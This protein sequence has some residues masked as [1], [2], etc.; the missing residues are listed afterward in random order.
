MEAAKAD[1][2]PIRS[3]EDLEVYQRAMKLVPR[4]YEV[5][6]SMPGFEHYDLAA[7]VRRAAKSVPTNIAEGYARRSSV[8]EFKKFLRIAMASANEMEV[9]LN[10]A[11]ELGYV[12][13]KDAEVWIADYDI[14]GRQLN[15]LIATWRS[16]QPPASSLKPQET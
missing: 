4:M 13:K 14:V 8:K 5:A 7:Q 11:A 10:I 2:K 12:P 16:L 15:R 3:Y 9:H 6:K 1:R